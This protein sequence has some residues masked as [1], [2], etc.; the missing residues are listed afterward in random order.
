MTMVYGN[1]QVE[2]WLVWLKFCYVVMPLWLYYPKNIY[3]W[4]EKLLDLMDVLNLANCLQTY[5]KVNPGIFQM[6]GI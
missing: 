1:G 5:E 3:V 6:Q 4:A 2:L